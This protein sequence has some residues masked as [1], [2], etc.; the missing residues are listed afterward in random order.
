M[1]C[2][3]FLLHSILLLWF[4]TFVVSC[5]GE[6]TQMEDE[7]T[8]L[9]NKEDESWF[10]KQRAACSLEAFEACCAKKVLNVRCLFCF[11]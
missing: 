11:Q 9:V 1:F 3:I 5:R 4:Y 10:V 6:T 7:C 8:A 2:G